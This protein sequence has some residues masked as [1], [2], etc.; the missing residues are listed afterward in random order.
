MSNCSSGSTSCHFTCPSGGTWYA[1]PNE[2]YFLGCCSSDPCTN[3]NRGGNSTASPCPDLYPASF[4]TAIFDAIRPNN[5]LEGNSSKWYTC[6]DIPVPFLGCCTSNPCSDGCPK[7]DLRAAAWSGSRGDQLQLFEDAPTD[8]GKGLSGGAIAGIVIGCVAGVAIL[9]LAIWF[10]VRRRKKKNQTPA[11]GAPVEQ[12][13]VEYMY[14]NPPVSPY[15]GSSCVLPF[16]SLRSDSH[17]K[18]KTNICDNMIDTSNAATSV[19]GKYPSGSTGLSLPSFSPPLSGNERHSEDPQYPQ[20]YQH[21][22]STS[23]DPGL[24]VSGI[25]T[26]PE[27]IPELDGTATTTAPAP[28]KPPEINELDGSPPK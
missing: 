7:R 3:T 22:R 16:P 12:R 10:F 13:L 1:C 14:P 28:A 25:Q 4:D 17:E 27:T 9:I 11:W 6:A 18:Q 8:D 20:H 15:P 19:S 26:M 21:R 23:Q 5:C 24:G 2:P